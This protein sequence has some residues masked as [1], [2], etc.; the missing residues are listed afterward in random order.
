MFNILILNNNKHD[1]RLP[2]FEMEKSEM[3]SGEENDDQGSNYFRR[4]RDDDRDFSRIERTSDGN[5]ANFHGTQR[6][7]SSPCS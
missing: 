7:Y 4:R 6:G 1:V 5:P 3:I 2:A